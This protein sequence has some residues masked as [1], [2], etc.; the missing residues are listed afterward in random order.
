[1][2]KRPVKFWIMTFIGM[3]F[4]FFLFL[5]FAFDQDDGMMDVFEGGIK[6]GPKIGLVRLEGIILGS[7]DIIKQLKEFKEDSS[8]HAIIVRINSPGGAVVPSQDIYEELSK[9]REEGKV[10]LVASMGTVAASGG[11]YIASATDKIYASPGTLTGSI[12]VIMELPNMEGLMNK[13]GVESVVI[14]SGDYK[15]MGSLFRK[16]GEKEIDVLQGVMDDIYEQFLDAVAIGRNLSIDEVRSLANGKIYTGRQAVLVGLVD[17]IGNF[18]D[19]IEGTAK[20]VGIKGK[21]RLVE[22]KKRRSLL[23]YIEA[24]VGSINPF[25]ES[26]G[27]RFSI[28][29]LLTAG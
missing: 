2:L 19:A 23:E 18:E 10:K 6:G 13:L 12:G 26:R 29:Y 11:Y 1:M 9:I 22:K 4:V 27:T 5:L 3:L 15:D 28:K 20:M 8:I 7:E 24:G 25:L 14:K 17:E 16:I 21:P